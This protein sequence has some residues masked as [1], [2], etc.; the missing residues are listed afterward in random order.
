MSSA[1]ML[2]AALT[3]VPRA[4]FETLA[5]VA[6]AS[7]LTTGP[8][9]ANVIET[10]LAGLE[11][12]GTERALCIGCKVGYTVALLSHLAREVHAIELDG[13][14]AEPERFVLAQLGR[15]NVSMVHADGVRSR[16]SAAP[17][18]AIVVTCA[19]PELPS[20]LIEDLAVGGRIVIPLGGE[21]GQLI[22]RLEKRVD[23]LVSRTLCSCRLPLLPSLRRAS[24]TFP[25]S[26]SRG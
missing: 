12:D 9:P 7:T 21:S 24:S 5:S 16:H 19:A 18:Q 20:A 8:T 3:K 13:S 6:G 1:S 25:W 22:E 10:M 11:L 4:A 14:L 26:T 23:S 15:T 17:F 2:A